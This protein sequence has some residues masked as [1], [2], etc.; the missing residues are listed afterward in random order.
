MVE[1]LLANRKIRKAVIE[2]VLALTVAVIGI[3][4]DDPELAAGSGGVWVLQQVRR[5]ARDMMSGE[6]E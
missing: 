5:I 3:V 4:I 2:G 1:K 6:P